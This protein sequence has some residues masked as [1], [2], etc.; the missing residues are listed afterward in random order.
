MAKWRGDCLP[1]HLAKKKANLDKSDFQPVVDLAK[2]YSR[3]TP[4]RPQ[5]QPQS[6]S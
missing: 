1:P 5:Q 2:P 4:E 6:L 3:R